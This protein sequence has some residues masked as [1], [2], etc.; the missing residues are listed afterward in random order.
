MTDTPT[1]DPPHDASYWFLLL[2]R[3]RSDGRFADADRCLRELARLGV[4][5]QWRRPRREPKPEA[6]P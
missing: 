5:V 4:S 1:Y 2:D 6:R 3:A